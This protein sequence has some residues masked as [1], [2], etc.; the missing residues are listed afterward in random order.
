MLE[1]LAASALAGMGSCIP[2]GT[3]KRS[4][5][6]TPR[7]LGDG[8]EL[9]KPEA[10]GIDSARLRSAFER[11]FSEDEFLDAVSCLVVCQGKLIAE[12]YVRDEADAT[13]REFVQ[14]VTKSVVSMAFGA[15]QSTG[16]LADLD[17]PVARFLDVHDPAKQ[18][19]TLRHL[20]TMRTGIDID[21]TTFNEEASMRQRHALTDWILS[22]PLFAPPGS[23]FRYADCN[24]QVLASVVEAATAET[25]EAIARRVIFSPLGIADL[26]WE[27]DADGEP[28]GPYGL[29][30]RPRDFAKLGE[31]T[32]L[33]GTWNGTSLVPQVWMDQATAK[34]TETPFST[35]HGVDYG[36][37]FW[38]AHEISG[39]STWGHGGNYTV[40][41]PSHELVLVLTGMPNAGDDVA[42]QLWDAVSL[43]KTIIGA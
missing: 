23:T 2:N 17:A 31:L 3:F 26:G 42:P 6:M 13:R 27:H 10:T 37:Y 28:L 32:R 16:P 38:V 15:S 5:E 43:V 30:L 11:V 36:F 24:P 20:L 8:W 21:Q 41:A 35:S 40:V 4:L 12:G 19:L 18:A 9:A 25:V 14:S 29:S 22:Q 34:Q 1:I 7:D 39:F 33:G